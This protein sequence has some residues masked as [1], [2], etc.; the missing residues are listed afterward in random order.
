M[1]ILGSLHTLES[2]GRVYEANG[3]LELAHERYTRALEGRKAHRDG[4]PRHVT[5]LTSAV[6]R[7]A[8]VIADENERVE[9]TKSRHSFA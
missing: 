9:M 3:D 6:E 1:K 8:T 4:N 5:S 2:T 7:V